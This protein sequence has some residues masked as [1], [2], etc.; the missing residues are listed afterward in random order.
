MS[1]LK[2][3]LATWCKNNSFIASNKERQSKIKKYINYFDINKNP[4]K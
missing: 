3:S 4:D 1:F 2:Y